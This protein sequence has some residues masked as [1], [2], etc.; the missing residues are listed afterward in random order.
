MLNHDHT[1]FYEH[2]FCDVWTQLTRLAILLSIIGGLAAN[3]CGDKTFRI[4]PLYSH[5]KP[6][7]RPA[8]ELNVSSRMVCST[9]CYNDVKCT[10]FFYNDDGRCSMFNVRFHSLS[11]V[12]ETGTQAY[13]AVSDV[14]S[15]CYDVMLKGD[16]TSAVYTIVPRDNGAPINVSCEEEGW[17]VIQR[18]TDG[19]HDFYRTWNEYR[20]GFGDLNNEFW[21]G[22]TNIHRIT[23]QGLYDLR[24]DLE[25]F[26]G[27]TAYAMYKNFSLA[28]EQDYF[29]LSIGEYSG[30][31]GDSLGGH[32]GYKFSAKDVDVDTFY[33][34]C[35][36]RFKGAWWFSKCH[37][38]D[39]N[40]QYLGGSHN[41]YAA[42]VVWSSWRGQYYS[43]KTSVMKI[44]PMK[45]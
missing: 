10:G 27:N 24:I 17:L 23:S 44:R 7:E 33:S 9:R 26:E 2:Y 32:T 35:A 15:D 4:S 43:M 14:P 1:Y 30:D 19:S 13:D 3:I 37:A 8:K 25:D 12:N 36:Q 31:A 11:F 38:S 18:R 42:G 39:L 45:F 40:G 6:V 5:L 21:L 16:S 20:D 29:R 22:N 41:T 28:S 34:S